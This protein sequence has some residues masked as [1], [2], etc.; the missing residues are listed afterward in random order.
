MGKCGAAVTLAEVGMTRNT[1]HYRTPDALTS[2]WHRARKAAA[3]LQPAAG[4]VRPLARNAGAVARHQ[5]DKTR[6]WAAPQVER[7]GQVLQ[8][9]IAPKASSLLSAAAR[10]IDPAPPRSRQWRKLAG[11]S[12]A[13]AAATAAA[14]A[15]RARLRAGASAAT[16]PPEAST[17][18]PAEETAP[19]AETP[20]GQRS[21]GGEIDPTV[22]PAPGNRDVPAAID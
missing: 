21:P 5:A 19:P 12:A 2:A 16:D 13:A 11:I 8:D 7:T 4:Q 17:T 22:P 20:N 18:T 15:L 1:L 6:T 14:A 10:R 3:R 9:S